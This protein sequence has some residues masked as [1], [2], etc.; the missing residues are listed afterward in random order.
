[1]NE[2]PWMIDDDD[3]LMQSGDML[4]RMNY[5]VGEALSDSRQLIFQQTEARTIFG[6]M[7]PALLHDLKRSGAQSS[8]MSSINRQPKQLTS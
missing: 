2:N 7:R 1:M 4:M 5:L 3:G 6:P 8:D